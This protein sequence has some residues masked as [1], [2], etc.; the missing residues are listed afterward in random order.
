[1]LTCWKRL[2]PNLAMERAAIY[3]KALSMKK[4]FSLSITIAL[5]GCASPYVPPTSGPTA[6]I[7]FEN[8]AQR[9]L[10]ISYFDQSSQC[11]GR[12]STEVILP[13]TEQEHIVRANSDLTFQYYLTNHNGGGHEQYC[14]MNLRFHPKA[15]NVYVFRTSEGFNNC[16]WLMTDSTDANAPTPIELKRIVWKRGFDESSSWCNE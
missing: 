6:K 15:S 3:F 13:T 8:D 10:Y 11:V 2:A 7:R 14:L 5:V 12:R 9:N 1:M 16:R 4:F